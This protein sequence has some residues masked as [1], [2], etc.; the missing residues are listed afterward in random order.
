LI[1]VAAVDV[2]E[3]PV[4]KWPVAAATTH[5]RLQRI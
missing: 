5:A 4:R 3:R 2:A 1:D